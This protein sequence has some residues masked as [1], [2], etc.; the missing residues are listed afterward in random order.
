MEQ[1]IG[2]PT[3]IWLLISEWQDILLE[4]KLRTVVHTVTTTV[5]VLIRNVTLYYQAVL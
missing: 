4:L 3:P 1:V 2:P 5:A